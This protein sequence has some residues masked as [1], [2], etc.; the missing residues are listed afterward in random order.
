MKQTNVLMT[1]L[2]SLIALTACGKKQAPATP[3]PV[4]T[5]P[6]PAAAETPRPANP[7]N[8]EEEARRERERNRAILMEMVF[9]EYDRSELTTESRAALDRKVPVLR[10]NSDVV[11]TIEGH[12]DERGSVEYNLALGLR[13]AAAVRDYLTGFGIP[14]GRL[15]IQSF[16]EEKPL[17]SGSDE[18]AWSRNRRAEFRI[19]AG[20]LLTAR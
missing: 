9:F 2:V 11:V 4:N 17:D 1:A 8:A 16:G 12:A 19:T 10:G 3:E 7:S 20:G 6:P 15:E 13:R 18:S 5:T 14:I